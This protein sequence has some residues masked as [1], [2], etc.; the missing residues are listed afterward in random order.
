MRLS[1]IEEAFALGKCTPALM[2]QF[3]SALKHAPRDLRP[4]H[5]YTTAVAMPLWQFPT[6]KELIEYSLELEGTWL[7]RMRAHAA[8][9]ELY[10]KQ[11]D[12]QNAITHYQLALDAVPAERHDRY[13]PDSAARMLVCQ[14]HLDGFTYSDELRRLY[15]LA[16]QLDEFI[17]SFQKCRFYFSL[18]E[19]IQ[20]RHDGDLSAAR[21][22]YDHAADMLRP[23]HEG[24]ITALLKRKGHIESTGATA[25]ARAFLKTVAR[26]LK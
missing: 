1:E 13:A 21:A 5:C 20:Y 11:A 10:E 25:E 9:A 16:Q 18:A 15:E 24:P 14:L 12:Y 22:A 7:D 19:I 8:L 23:G 17:R 2:E 3:R 6:A 4:Q 26:S